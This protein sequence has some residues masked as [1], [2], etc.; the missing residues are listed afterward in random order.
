M[1]VRP[2]TWYMLCVRP[3]TWYVLC[4]CVGV[5]TALSG[6]GSGGAPRGPAPYEILAARKRKAAKANEEAFRAALAARG[7]AAPADLSSQYAAS[8]LVSDLAGFGQ[9]NSIQCIL[10]VHSFL[11]RIHTRIVS[12]R[13]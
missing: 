2:S 9:F 6:G 12:R 11:F 7:F 13:S 8:K 10:S 4:V 3:S 5:R 1:C